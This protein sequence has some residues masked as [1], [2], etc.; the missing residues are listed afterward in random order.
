MN[1][2]EDL[3][4][5]QPHRS[6]TLLP[7]KQTAALNTSLSHTFCTCLAKRSQQRANTC[8]QHRMYMLNHLNQSRTLLCRGSTPH[9]QI[10]EYFFFPNFASLPGIQHCIAKNNYLIRLLHLKCNM[11]LVARLCMEYMK[12]PPTGSKFRDTCPQ[13]HIDLYCSFCTSRSSCPSSS[14]YFGVRTG[15]WGGRL[16]TKRHAMMHKEQFVGPLHR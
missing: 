10:Q 11:N 1:Y 2:P 12:N 16:N 15:I 14:W 4:R 7:T 5:F 8:Q 6:C 3:D 9:L 13:H